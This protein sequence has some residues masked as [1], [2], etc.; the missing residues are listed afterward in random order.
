[1]KKLE[2]EIPVD[3]EVDWEVSAK[4]KQIVL[5]DK[6]LTYKDVCK[7]LF[8]NSHYFIDNT[9]EIHG[10]NL[11]A[12]DSNAATSEH[13]LKCIL[14]KNKLANTARYLNGDWTKKE[15]ADSPNWVIFFNT[16]LNRIIIQKTSLYSEQTNIVFKYKELAQQAIEILGEET[17]K[18]ALEPLY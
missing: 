12:Y 17:V 2:I 9:G 6:K 10:V 7:E 18:L 13:Q 16:R 8:K 1:M 15:Q 14:A 4:Q 5:K 11:P 3:K